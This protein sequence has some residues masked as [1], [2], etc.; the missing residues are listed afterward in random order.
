MKICWDTLEKLKYNKKRGCWVVLAWAGKK[1]YLYRDSCINCKDPYLTSYDNP[2][3][4]C[5]VKCVH[6]KEFHNWTGKTHSEST[7]KLLSD[8]RKGKKI[9]KT[10]IRG[11]YRKV[12]YYKRGLSLYN[13]Y[14][15]QIDWCE[16]VRR[17]PED[18]N[19]LNVKCAYC[20]KWYRPKPSQVYT[21]IKSLDGK[22]I[23]ENRLYC[24]S[25]CKLQCP[26]FH[27]IRY[28]S[29]EDGTKQMSR[30]VQAEL[31]QLVFE[32]DNW[33][34]VKCG[35]TKSLHCHHIEGVRW[36]PIESADIDGCITVCGFCHM[37][38]HRK[39]GCSQSDM[40]CRK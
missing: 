16:P 9:G 35:A 36:N 14:A 1:K 33:A 22:I 10:G 31:R 37:E 25:E 13:T 6:S 40:I 4:F 26:I 11:P 24:S 21:R 18:S 34:C 17:D 5:S 3:N 39:K 27:K 12:T 2:G 8:Q 19:I 32:R 30:E 7:R 15:H 20:G 29:E 23:G 38:I 28:S